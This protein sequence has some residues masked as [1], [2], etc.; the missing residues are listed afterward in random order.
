MSHKQTAFTL[1]E[2]MIALT[3]FAFI[4]FMIHF[5]SQ[6]V[7]NEK[8]TANLINYQRTLM[9]LENPDRQYEWDRQGNQIYFVSARREDQRVYFRLNKNVLQLT[10]DQGGT[11]P[12]VSGVSDFKLLENQGRLHFV[13]IFS[14]KERY[15]TDLLL[16][17]HLASKD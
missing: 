8:K 2:T 14:R 9:Q 1:A 10:T 13:I 5:A 6:F 3:V 15:E 4:L 7:Q 17:R 16:K 12:I 11:M